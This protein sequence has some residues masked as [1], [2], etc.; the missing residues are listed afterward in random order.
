[1]DDTAAYY[2]AINTKNKR[3]KQAW[4]DHDEKRYWIIN[5]AIDAVKELWLEGYRGRYDTRQVLD[6][7]YRFISP[8]KPRARKKRSSPWLELISPH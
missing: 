1:M 5:T 3:Y 2:A 6:Q 4:L 7:A 8:L